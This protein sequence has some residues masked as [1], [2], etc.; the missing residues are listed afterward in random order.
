MDD[1]D[2]LNQ[3]GGMSGTEA[4]G[5]RESVEALLL[6]PI[7]HGGRVEY[8]DG[9][10]FTGQ[11]YVYGFDPDMSDA[12]VRFYQILYG[13]ELLDGEGRLRS[14]EFAGDTMCSFHTVANRVPEA[15]RTRKQRRPYAEWP[16]YLQEYYDHYHCL[17]NFW[18]LPMRV[19][20]AVAGWAC[21]A[22]RGTRDY[23]DRFL[24]N[25]ISEEYYER[26][27]ERYPACGARF[28]S[29][30]IFAQAH[31]LCGPGNYLRASPGPEGWEIELYSDYKKFLP[32]EIVQAMTDRIRAR[33]RAISEGPHADELYQWYTELC[34]KRTMIF[35]EP[36]L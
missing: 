16:G 20:R 32:E 10:L 31:A 6:A 11:T 8:R 28:P 12:A 24:R 36:V 18:L 21:K 9:K 19:G 17:A 34:E 4:A 25:L 14:A 22:G 5:K 29:F 7:E 1:F 2:F 33:A 15:G 30:E 26:F 3:N 27:K 13:I 35:G 23:M